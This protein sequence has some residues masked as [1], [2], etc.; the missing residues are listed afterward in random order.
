M[1][2]ST[3]SST[4]RETYPQ[5][6]MAVIQTELKLLTEILHLDSTADLGFRA[7]EIEHLVQKLLKRLRKVRTSPLGWMKSSIT[8]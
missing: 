2:A 7:L 6:V 8:L 3:S 4:V 5:S 1:E